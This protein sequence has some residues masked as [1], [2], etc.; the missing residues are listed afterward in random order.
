[1]QCRNKPCFT[2]KKNLQKSGT[3]GVYFSDVVTQDVLRDVCQRITGLSE[4][5]LCLIMR[6]SF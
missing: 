1:M 5:D 4:F 6:M 2:I 3:T